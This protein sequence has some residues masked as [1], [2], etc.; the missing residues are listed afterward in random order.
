MTV[1]YNPSENAGAEWLPAVR[2][3][4]LFMVLCGGLYPLVV[5][6]LSGA[7]FPH[8]ATG[9]LIEQ[10]GRVVGSELVG[11]AFTAPGYFH[12]RPSAAGYDPFSVS[13]SNLAPSNPT[14]RDRVKADAHAI[15]QDNGVPMSNI[16]VDL[17]TASGSGIDPHISPEAAAIQIQRV[18]KARSVTPESLRALITQHTERP[19]WGMLGQ[20]RVNVLELNLALDTLAGQ[21]DKGAH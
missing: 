4:V 7:L 13:G 1:H 6:T 20:P 15:A 9:S 11:Q 18:A 14:L 16:P 21:S 19:T 12:G 2:T 3:A 5:T 8:Q 10:N 17:V